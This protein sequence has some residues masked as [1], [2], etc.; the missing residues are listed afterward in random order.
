MQKLTQPTQLIEKSRKEHITMESNYYSARQLKKGSR[1][2]IVLG[3][4]KNANWQINYGSGKE[5]SEESV[6]DAKENRKIKWMPESR[7]KIP[8]NKFVVN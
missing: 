3:V 2:I 4:N 5:V 1:I 6:N 7:I 8:V